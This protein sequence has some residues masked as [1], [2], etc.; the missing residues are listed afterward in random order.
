[1]R[2]VIALFL[3]STLIISCQETQV[4][5][6]RNENIDPE[7]LEEV[8]ALDA[9]VVE[10]LRDNDSEG[11]KRLMSD[12]LKAS[13]SEDLSG[14][15]ERAQRSIESKQYIT[16]DQYHRVGTANETV[17][18]ISGTDKDDDYIIQ[19]QSITNESFVSV[20]APKREG[21]T[22]LLTTFYGRFEDDWKLN[23]IQ[24]E[25]YTLGGLSSIQLFRE[26]QAELEKGYVVNAFNR[27]LLGQTCSQPAGEFWQFR[28]Q[29]EMDAF[30][31]S[32]TQLAQGSYPMPM[33]VDTIPTK[34]I[35]FQITPQRVDLDICTMIKYVSGINI[36]DTLALAAENKMLHELARKKFNGIDADV[37]FIFYRAFNEMPKEGISTPYFGF[38]RPVDERLL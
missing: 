12:D 27:M 29:A 6:Y 34:P 38:V 16:V 17:A 21:D 9:Q 23:I 33:V 10:A 4:G 32:L 7:V 19:Y 5:T 22:Y 14:F 20:I 31:D 25:R 3:T 15:M 2:L 30:N 24:F 8:R 18:L 28:I 35:I 13:V 37:P 36:K 1:M 11:L 26:A